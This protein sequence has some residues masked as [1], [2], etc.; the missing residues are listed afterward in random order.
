MKRSNLYSGSA[1]ISALSDFRDY[2]R[3]SPEYPES[4]RG[5]DR[6]SY[7]VEVDYE[8]PIGGRAV[9]FDTRFTAY[10]GSGLEDGTLDLD[11]T[12][13]IGVDDYHLRFKPRWQTYRFEEADGTLVVEGVSAKGDRYRV[14]IR[15]T[16]AAPTNS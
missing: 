15:P 3:R 11:E 14:R 5:N 12:D 1:S 2:W 9:L 8:I 6:V 4:N 13:R 10:V 7:P 16:I